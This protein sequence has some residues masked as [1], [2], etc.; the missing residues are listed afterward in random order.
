MILGQLN[1][2]LFQPLSYEIKTMQLFQPATVTGVQFFVFTQIHGLV[3]DKTSF[4]WKVV[5][6]NWKAQYE[7]LSAMQLTNTVRVFHACVMLGIFFSK[8]IKM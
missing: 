5:G 8:N 7:Y 6:F 3:M 4:P 1:L 2:P